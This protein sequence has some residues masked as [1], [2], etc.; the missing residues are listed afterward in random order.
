MNLGPGS[1][2]AY[3]DRTLPSMSLLQHPRYLP[4]PVLGRGA[5]GVVLRVTDRESPSRAL[6]AKLWQPGAFDEQLLMGEFALLSRLHVPGLVRAHDLGRD[7]VSEAPF[8]VEDFVDGPDA[9]RFLEAAPSD[10][11]RAE[12]LASL[13]SEVTA[14]LALVHDSGFLHGDLKPAHVRIPEDG[15][16]TLIDLGAAVARAR[17][18]LAPNAVTPGYAAPEL[19]AGAPPSPKT[20]LFALGAL[21]YSVATGKPPESHAP[22]RSLA[23]WLPPSLADVVDRLRSEHPADRP[24][25][26]RDVLQLLGQS[27][28]FGAPRPVRS[29]RAGGAERSVRE[30]QLLGLQRAKPG[31]TYLVGAPGM[32]KSQV[33]SE[34][35]TRALL[36]GHAARLLRFPNDDHQLVSRLIAWLRGSERARPFAA[37]PLLV[38][39]DDAHA[40]PMEVRSALEAFRC[41]RRGPAEGSLW[42]PDDTTLIAALRDAPADANAIVLGALDLRGVR[43]L[44]AELDVDPERAEELRNASDGN[45]GFIAAL[46]GRV[47]LER[48]AVLAR[49]KA[50]APTAARALA[51]V[52]VLDGH[53]SDALLNDVL[54][55]G[56]A[57][58][59]C[60]ELARASLLQRRA[61]DAGVSWRLTHTEIQSDIA[62]ALASFEIVDSITD[63]V[64]ANSV[65]VS[66]AQLLSLS[67]ALSPPTRRGELLSL[68]ARTA[69][70]AGLRSQETDALLALAADPRE[71]TPETLTALDRSTR[72]GGSA[73]L[74]PELVTWLEAAAA[75]HPALA[76]LALRRRA[77]QQARAG[78]HEAAEE[79]AQRAVALAE[80]PADE[81]LALSTL[82]STALYRADWTR[83]ELALAR[84][85]DALSAAAVDDSEE[86]AR[87]DHNRG[88]VALYRGRVDEA[89]EAFEQ[90]LR[91]K[92]EMGDRGGTW[93]CLLNLGLACS[94]LA[95][96]DQ[97]E[98]ALLEAVATCR[99]LSQLSGAGWCLA[100]LADVSLRRGDRAAAERFVSEA[101]HLGDVIPKP[102]H[103]D[104][105]LLRAEIALAE[106]KGDLALTHLGRVDAALVEQDALLGAR[107]LTLRASAHLCTLPADRGRAAR[108]AVA[109]A[110]RAR[111]AG[112]PEPE[113]RAL[114]VLAAARRRFAS[115]PTRGY[116]SVPS[117]AGDEQLWSFLSAASIA[118]DSEAAALALCRW[119]VE[120]SGA[121]RAFV[122]AMAASGARGGVGVDIEGVPIPD[123]LERVSAETLESALSA[124]DISHQPTV[125]TRGGIGSRLVALGPESARAER[126]LLV[127]EHRFVAN[128]FEKLD[129]REVE[130][131]GICAA[132]AVALGAGGSSAAA[133]PPSRERGSEAPDSLREP[134]TV[135]PSRLGHRAF[136][137]IIGESAALQRA[138]ARLD[139]AVD[140]DLPVLITGETGVG[141]EL[142]ARA[143]H[144]S[145]P[146]A[147]APFVAINCGAVPDALFE[148]ELFGHA[149][150]S[151][152]GADRARAGLIA[153]AEGGTLLLDEIGEL[154]MM[155]QATLLRA[156]A[157]RRYRPV[158]SDEEKPFD[159]RVIAATNR[160]LE[161]EVETGGFRRDLLYRLNVLEVRV[162]PLRERPEDI[163]AIAE[164]VLETAG[165][166]STLTPRAARA[167]VSHRWPGN[168]REL[169]HQM[170]RVAALGVP[171]IEL[172]HLARE[173]RA[174]FKEAPAP[175]ISLAPN[176]KAAGPDAERDEV[177]AALEREGGNITRAAERLRITRH[178]LKKKMIR[179]GMRSPKVSG[180]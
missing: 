11:A 173:V 147:S 35:V 140:S 136:P 6:V 41:R 46:T 175:R 15:R 32:G 94:Q 124:G 172:E 155:R 17:L 163:L 1:P 156:L 180:G 112:L 117:M 60:A 52:A 90:S 114:G 64:L 54:G 176:K 146:R 150:G 58:Q 102:V 129:R 87:L 127:L 75:T 132:L 89:L 148:A 23:T 98:A 20:D 27:V 65:G 43:G 5:Q 45:P 99:A 53:A 160:D 4:G 26:A 73:G 95:R 31:L 162:P 121:E 38:A 137:N 8:L 126:A 51:T 141:K 115:A 21:A 80:Q 42:S 29:L 33:L 47:P 86:L 85:T 83:A 159:V 106:G 104:L 19:R 158:G 168:V 62:D 3:K 28:V 167:L 34:L 177:R 24:C 76:V 154:P 37:G 113:Q 165:S 16:A 18:D 118:A 30:P 139:T 44:C 145:G 178:G 108:A 174:A 122:I 50:L 71:R 49:A 138:L 40:A 128:A 111:A 166:K 135:L 36:S 109:A 110:R 130:R 70:D 171:R 12:R 91:A 101:E 107:S 61:G 133:A 74:H 142:F 84:A 131:W 125:A 144:D 7:E 79:L 151:F 149:R 57:R 2:P 59:A 68:A 69:R 134:S 93:A 39:L 103:A 152:T 97:A 123:V 48:A 25:D 81:V 77:E 82:A 164:R 92:R 96:Y 179:L 56:E 67:R 169:E 13:L 72:G 100:A 88:V 119:V 153:R 161:H 14:T 170:Q 9:R 55:A 120:A 22:V 143:L 78:D 116:A 157:E 63:H 105:A 10:R 66:A